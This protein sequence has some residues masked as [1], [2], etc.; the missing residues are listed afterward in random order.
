MRKD[1]SRT[2]DMDRLPR[3]GTTGYEDRRDLVR[4][5]YQPPLWKFYSPLQVAILTLRLSHDFQVVDQ[6]INPIWWWDWE[7]G[8]MRLVRERYCVAYGIG[9]QC[10]INLCRPAGKNAG[11]STKEIPFHHWQYFD[12]RRWKP[13]ETDCKKMWTFGWRQQSG[14]G[15]LTC[16]R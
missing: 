6:T 7:I 4:L 8:R 11:H 5:D 15:H 12:R 14:Y 1:G 9:P 10:D 16:S 2:T 13:V 3:F